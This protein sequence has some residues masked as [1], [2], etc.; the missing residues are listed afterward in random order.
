MEIKAIELELRAAV[1]HKT[2]RSWRSIPLFGQAQPLQQHAVA[3]IAAQSLE[4]RLDFEVP[5]G[6]L[7]VDARIFEPRERGVAVTQ[8][9][10]R[11]RKMVAG[12]IAAARIRF[13]PGDDRLCFAAS[14]G[15][16]LR[17][18]QP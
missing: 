4:W 9:G 18:R 2:G 10:M 12:H 7:P 16:G 6:G 13:E 11:Q 8:A 14:A 1:L 3:R 15:D 17:M 5:D